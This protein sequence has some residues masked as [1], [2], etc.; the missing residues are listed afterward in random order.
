MVSL[1]CVICSVP[2]H[3]VSSGWIED[4]NIKPYHEYKDQMVPLGKP[5]AH[6]EKAIDEIE[7]YMLNPEVIFVFS[8][9]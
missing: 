4:F 2:F 8:Y 9:V 1:K 3:F 7:A 5:K 6:F